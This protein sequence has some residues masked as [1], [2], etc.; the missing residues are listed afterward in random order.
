[1]K[2][3][4]TAILRADDTSL[5]LAVAALRSSKVVAM[6]TETVYGLA[7]VSF[8]E[9][10]LA[11]IFAVKER[12]TFDPLICHVAPLQGPADV[13]LAEA[14]LLDFA[15]LTPSARIRL[16]KLTETFWPGPLTVVIPRSSRVP[17]LVTSGLDTVGVRCPAHPIAQELLRC[18]NAPLSAPS[19]NRFGRVSPTTAAHVLEELGGRIEII[20]DG[21]P[22]TIGIESTVVAVSDPPQV[23]RPGSIS[24]SRIAKLLGERVITAKPNA[25]LAQV[26]PGMLDRHYAPSKTFVRLPQPV[27]SLANAA[28]EA[29]RGL[30]AQK[31]GPLGL[32][33]V[34][35]DPNAAA[36]RLTEL[37]ERDVFAH[38]LSP[39]GDTA[40]AARNLFRTLRLLDSTAAALLVAE[41]MRDEDGLLHA[42]ADRLNR[43]TTPLAQ[44]GCH[45]EFT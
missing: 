22:A 19:A 21:G 8:D 26:S 9:T 42:I 5:E 12:P 43:A 17:D 35:G 20:L 18:V 32:I 30:V 2:L 41:P 14:G 34:L 37:V 7:G 33:T 31:E 27:C 1:M 40:E 23:L 13:A 11:S 25:A 36:A 16:L 10:A 45:I 4:H 3:V 6:P 39:T 28:I 38:S 24:E 15:K 29:L 44:T